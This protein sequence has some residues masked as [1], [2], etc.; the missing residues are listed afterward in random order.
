MNTT[1]TPVSGVGDFNSDGKLDLVIRINQY[2]V[3]LGKG[4]GSFQTI[5]APGFP[6]NPASG[7]GVQI[8][9][10]A[11]MDGDGKSDAIVT[12]VFGGSDVEICVSK[13]NGQFETKGLIPFDATITKIAPVTADLNRD[14][15]PDIV[16]LGTN[17]AGASLVVLINTSTSVH[18]DRVQ[19]GASFALDQAVAPGSLVSLFGSGFAA[20]GT[21]FAASTAKLPATLGDVS[22]TFNGITAPVSY[23]IPGQINAQV[24][25]KTTNPAKVVV[26]VKGAS[27][28]PLSIPIAPVAPGVF[29]ASGHAIAINQDGTLAA[30]EGAIPGLITHPALPGDIIIL[31]ATGLGAVD[32]PIDDGAPASDALRMAATPEVLIGGVSAHV[33]FAGLTPQFAGVNQLNV[34]VPDVPTGNQPVQINAG[35][36]LSTDQTSMAIGNP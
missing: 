26:T 4:D 6:A 17:A 11:D 35:G 22:V 15:K 7:I 5:L 3:L 25:W 19:N 20:P 13:G 21:V 36:I 33:S 18:L 34:E 8:A 9:A 32:P 12:A 30:P 14:G 2:E 10:I 16:L 27:S 23:V 28:P 29:A 1:N 31:Y 24:P